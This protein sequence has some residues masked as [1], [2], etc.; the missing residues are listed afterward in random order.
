MYAV[1]IVSLVYTI[2]LLDI[3][4]RV[5][6]VRRH[7][8]VRSSVRVAVRGKRKC[9][10]MR[11]V[12][13]GKQK[14]CKMILFLNPKHLTTFISFL[15]FFFLIIVPPANSPMKEI[16]KVVNNA[17]KRIILMI[18]CQT[19]ENYDC[20][21]AKDVHVALGVVRNLIN[22]FIICNVCN[23]NIVTFSFYLLFFSFF[24]FFF[25]Y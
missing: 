18:K 2:H 5:C 9:Q 16:Y 4:L 21:V 25:D 22:Y 20:H 12:K 1:R 10:T 13:F 15:F 24:F 7:L 6:C 14:K 23:N 19:T 8:L 17:Q 11:L 3:N